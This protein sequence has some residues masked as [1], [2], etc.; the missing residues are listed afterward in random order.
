MTPKGL[1]EW[2][3]I[4]SIEI[5]PTEPGGLYVAGTRYKLDDFR[6]YLYRTTD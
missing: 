4:N 2:M 5:H 6:P 1:P 3:Q